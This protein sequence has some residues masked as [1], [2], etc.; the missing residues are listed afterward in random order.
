MAQAVRV[1]LFLL[2]TGASRSMLACVVDRL[3]GNG[4]ISGMGASARE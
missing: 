3:D 4:E 1:N 2:E